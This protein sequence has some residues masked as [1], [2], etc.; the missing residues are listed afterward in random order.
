MR[1][2]LKNTS[3]SRLTWTSQIEVQAGNS[4]NPVGWTKSTSGQAPITTTY[5][6][7]TSRTTAGNTASAQG[8]VNLTSPNASN[9]RR[10]RV[11]AVV[12]AEPG[13]WLEIYTA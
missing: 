2:Q 7:T 8:A 11:R 9:V 1:F 3:S 5:T 12:D 10:V 6:S 4:S 13:R